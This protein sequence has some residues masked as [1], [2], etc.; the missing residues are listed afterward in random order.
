MRRIALGGV[1]AA[2]L[3]PLLPL[4]VWSVSGQWRY[5]AVLPQ[6]T[7]A[8]GLQL[9]AEGHGEVLRG[10]LT[11]FTVAGAVALLSVAIG[12]PAGRALGL[13]RMRGRRV[14]QLT[15]LAP[16]L[17]PGLAVTLGIQVVFLRLGLA[18]TLPGV[19]LVHLVPAVPYAT[20]LMTAAFTTFDADHEQ[21]ARVLGAGPVRTTLLVTLPLLRQA[22]GA[23]ALLAFLISW[24]EY[25]LTLIVGAGQVK[26]LPILLF[27][28]IGSSD[29]TTAAALSLLLI[30][31]PLLLV[32][33]VAS[34][35]STALAPAPS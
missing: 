16:V 19:V 8:R 17:V 2:L 30:A 11:S 27:A 7:S 26:T 28:A 1:V 3:L 10:L 18:A 23:A 14:L 4:V 13:H 24:N 25:V 5:P 34:R 9:V 21:Q 22:I 32:A 20:L 33:L 15:L 6:R 12:V 35:W 29:T 31:P